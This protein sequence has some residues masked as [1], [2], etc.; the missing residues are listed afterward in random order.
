LKLHCH[1]KGV[2][3][4]YRYLSANELSLIGTIDRAEE[5]FE[6]YIWQ[7]DLL[8]LVPGYESVSSFTE[9]ELHQIISRQEKLLKEGGKVIGAFDT[10]TLAGVASVEQMRRGNKA[11]YCKM[12]ILYVSQPYRGKKVGQQLVE[13]SKIIARQFGATKMYISATPTRYTVDFYLAMGARLATEIDPELWN[14][15][16]EDIHLEMSV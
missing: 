1:F 12:D 10:D 2:N 11:E 6:K 13:E 15:E 14:L 5:I 9:E 3:L 8:I 16:P 4:I 7:T